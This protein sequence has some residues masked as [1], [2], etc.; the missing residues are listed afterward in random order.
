MHDNSNIR[1]TKVFSACPIMTHLCHVVHL[2]S[3]GHVDLLAPVLNN[4][5]SDDGCVNGWLE[6]DVL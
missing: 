2:P 6:L 4:E 5:T 3:D 1:D